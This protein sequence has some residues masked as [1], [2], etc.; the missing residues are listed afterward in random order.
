MNNLSLKVN[1]QKNMKTAVTSLILCRME[2]IN[3]SE[4][5]RATAQ[6]I[7]LYPWTVW[8]G[9]HLRESDQ[10]NTRKLIHTRNFLLQK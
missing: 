8:K 2:E 10:V 7:V 1:K 5:Y 6:D 9:K 3:R 4:T